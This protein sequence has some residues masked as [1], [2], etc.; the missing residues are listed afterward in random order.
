MKGDIR[1]AL[2][3]LNAAKQRATYDAVK[4]YLGF[5]TFDKIDWNEV[6]GPNRQYTSWVVNK[7]TGMPNG[8]KPADLHPDLM[9]SEEIIT[10][11]RQL[12]TAVEEFEGDADAT[13]DAAA[14][15]VE[16]ADCHGNNAAVI[17]PNCSKAYLISGFLNKGVRA[18]PHC[19]KS[20]AVFAEVKAEWEAQ[21]E[22]DVVES[23]QEASRLIFKKEWL[24]YDVWVTFSE[25]D[26]TYRYPHDQLLQT[27][28]SRLGVI[29]GTK[30]W[31]NDG[32]YS[33]PRLS[34]EQKKML[35]RYIAEVRNVPEATQAAETGFELPEIKTAKNAEDL[36][37]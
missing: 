23:E 13:V 35:K 34:G 22:D 11:G 33:F 32:V 21:H 27:F 18:C 20:K 12:Q 6:L 3:Y 17:C 5:G 15:R 28:I 19:G 36:E 31:I 9:S 16:V 2:D 8:Y 30:T 4:S 26:T 29:E 1:K 24:G 7:K 37:D 14:P 25:D 10:K